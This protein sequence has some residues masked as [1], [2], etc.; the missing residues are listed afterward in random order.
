MVQTLKDFEIEIDKSEVFRYLGYGKDQRPNSSIS[1]LIDDEIE[2][3]YEL[4]EPQ[5]FY[6]ISNVKRV[7]QS[8]VLLEGPLVVTSDV[9]SKAL[10][11]CQE[12]ALFVCTI[13]QHLEQRVTQLM[14]EGRILKATVLD[15][16]GSDAAEK[17]TCYLDDRVGELA[18]SNDEAAT[19]RYSPGYCDWEIS[20]QRVIFKAMNST[21]L[22][23]ELTDECLMLPRKSVSGL[24]GMGQFD[25][26]QARYS[27]CLFCTK[28]DCTSRR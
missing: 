17:T 9:L 12:A 5:C 16:I 11:R 28:T 4:I 25:K 22:G 23:V 27:P 10:S 13:G 14:D 20:Q 24:I 15:A 18:A 7:R 2:E 1:S 8:K 26:R 19:L 21:P 3:A 6:Q